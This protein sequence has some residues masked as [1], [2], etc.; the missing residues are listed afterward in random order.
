M[1]IPVPSP[2]SYQLMM[3]EHK[4]T[5]RCLQARRQIAVLASSQT[6]NQSQHPISNAREHI[7]SA[8]EH[9]KITRKAKQNTNSQTHAPDIAPETHQ[10]TPQSHQALRARKAQQTSELV[11]FIQA[12]AEAFLLRGAQEAHPV[13]P[14]PTV[15]SYAWHLN[16]PQTSLY[17]PKC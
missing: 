11:G 10:Q 2:I 16:I 3:A 7:V 14:Q 1:L 5:C 17:D 6:S 9:Q 4:G 13:P 15:S 8:H 12:R